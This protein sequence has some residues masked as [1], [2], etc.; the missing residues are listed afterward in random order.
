[1]SDWSK[2]PLAVFRIRVRI[3]PGVCSKFAFDLLASMRSRRSW[4]DGLGQRNVSGRRSWPRSSRGAEVV[5]NYLQ[6]VCTQ[7]E[8]GAFVIAAMLY[9]FSR[10]SLVR[11]RQRQGANSDSVSRRA[12]TNVLATSLTANRFARQAFPKIPTG[13]IFSGKLIY[14]RKL[15]LAV[16]HE[17]GQP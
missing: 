6:S 10:R 7:F 8:L 2:I 1:M 17:H 13:S 12:I 5:E 14:G 16:G 9:V 15:L 11:R 4:P 3:F